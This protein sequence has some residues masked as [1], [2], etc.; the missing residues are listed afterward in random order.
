MSWA[1]ARGKQAAGHRFHLGF[2]VD[3]IS[4]NGQAFSRLTW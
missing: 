3:N 1:I 4:K 2:V